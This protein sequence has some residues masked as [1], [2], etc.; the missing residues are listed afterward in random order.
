[1]PNHANHTANGH[2]TPTAAHSGEAQDKLL[3][4]AVGLLLLTLFI[5]VFGG[6][7][8]L[9]KLSNT[10]ASTSRTQSGI[11]IQ[12]CRSLY[13]ADV[14]SAQG[15]ALVVIL[16]GLYAVAAEDDAGLEDLLRVDPT[17]NKSMYEDTVGDIYAARDEYKR[18]VDLSNTDPDEFVR[19][20]KAKQAKK[21]KANRPVPS[22][23]TTRPGG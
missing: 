8:S 21:E 7:L 6:L 12:G 2:A 15:N 18:A 16:S 14:I 17:T 10:E 20:C 9:Y 4:V 3:K 5:V 13:N 1:M 22:S 23:S 19:T 11:D